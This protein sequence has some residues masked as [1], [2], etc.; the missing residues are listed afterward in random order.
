MYLKEVEK[1]KAAGPYWVD[2]TIVDPRRKMPADWAAHVR[3][4]NLTDVD[5]T[6]LA[7]GVPPDYKGNPTAL[8]YLLR[9]QFGKNRNTQFLSVIEPYGAKAFI[10]SVR[11]LVN[12]MNRKDGVAAVEV[13]LADGR[14]DVIFIRENLGKVEAGG[15][16]MNGRIGYVRFKG[17]RPRSSPC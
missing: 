14:R 10:A 11:P 17:A 4:H 16:S 8:R 6:A 7:T 5:E 9:S 12:T 1:G 13:A 15:A 3:V 2:W